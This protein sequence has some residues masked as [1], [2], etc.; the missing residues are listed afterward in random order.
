MTEENARRMGQSSAPVHHGEILQG[1]FR[2]EGGLRRGL[3]T[4]P[5]ALYSVQAHFIPDGH[6]GVTVLPPWKVKAQRAAELALAELGK[7]GGGLKLSGD[8][9]LGRG[10]GSSTSDVLAAVGAVQSAF[11][12]TLPDDVVARIA[13]RAETASD[14]LMYPSTTVLFAHR[15]GEVLED[16]GSPMPP[17][18]VLGF[19]SRPGATGTGVDTLALPPAAYDAEEIEHFAELRRMLGEAMAA[20]D[21]TLLGE[22]ATASTRINQ[23][24][25]PVPRLD[26]ILVIADEVGAVGVQTAHSGDIAGLMFDRGRLDVSERME[27]A[28]G[29][30]R[31]IEIT[32][33][34]EFE[35][36]G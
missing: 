13:V 32:E 26:R 35:T 34:W 3:V 27:R 11:S 15:D 7:T 9:P 8:V 25:L 4:L 10:F 24:R 14:S 30:L 19:G 36:G 22:V 29:L 18:S 12:L 1:V 21:V 20:K 31:D 17:L 33:Q 2:H 6:A 5:C 23:R 16:F 28:R